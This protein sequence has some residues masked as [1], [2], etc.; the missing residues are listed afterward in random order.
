MI[1]RFE[2]FNASIYGIYRDILKIERAAMVKHG[3]KGSYALYLSAIARHPDGLTATQLCEI[4]DKD[5]AAIS[6]VIGE[7]VQKGLVK[8]VSVNETLYRAMLKLTDEG[9]V[10]ADEVAHLA[11]IAVSKAT[12]GM[13]EENRRIMYECLGLIAS[14]LRSI[15]KDGLP[16][17]E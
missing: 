17:E 8:R 16:A 13:S 1:S 15:C 3:L 12:R 4:C 10:V 6:R 14:N 5:K 11:Q 9:Q 7:L 2:Q